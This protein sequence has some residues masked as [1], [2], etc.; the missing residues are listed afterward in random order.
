MDMEIIFPE[1]KKVNALYR[2]FTIKTD[3]SPD[4]G[5][6][7]SAPTPFDLFLASIG[8]CTGIYVLLFCQARHIPTEK[9]K[10]L[11]RTERDK[12]TRMINKIT[13]EIQLP[14]EFPEK[15]REQVIRVAGKC[16]VKKHLE[17]PPLFDIY[18]KIVNS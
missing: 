3:Q 5:G 2:G 13:I 14:P 9:I 7:G 17:N 15:Y 11:L 16:S 1:G 10:L 8:T 18:T 4:N 12:K 6:G